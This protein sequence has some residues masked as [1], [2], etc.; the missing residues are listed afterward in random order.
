MCINFNERAAVILIQK[1]AALN[2]L[3]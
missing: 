2:R 3:L 1:L